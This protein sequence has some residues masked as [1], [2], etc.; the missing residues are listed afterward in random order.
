MKHI[1]QL[2]QA[3][4]GEESYYEVPEG[5][6][7][8]IECKQGQYIGKWFITLEE[9]EQRDDIAPNLEG[10]CFLVTHLHPF[11]FTEPIVPEQSVWNKEIYSKE[12]NE[13]HNTLFTQYYLSRD[14]VNIGEIVIWL[15]D[16][17]YGE[18]ATKLI[19]WWKITSK[20]LLYYLDTVTEETAIP[21]QD[22]I[23][24]LP[25]IQF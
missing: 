12:L 14:Y 16:D 7:N 23:N 19:N 17:V 3:Y 20:D 5:T 25:I 11:L 8:A 24:S 18:E 4:N 1:Q 6:T 13:A 15:D 22:Y 2:R 21:I 9:L 10:E